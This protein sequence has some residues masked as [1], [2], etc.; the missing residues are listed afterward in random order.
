MRDGDNF[1]SHAE[2]AAVD[3][4]PTAGAET[5]AIGRKRGPAYGGR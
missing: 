1:L 5:A 3:A 4:P 2:T